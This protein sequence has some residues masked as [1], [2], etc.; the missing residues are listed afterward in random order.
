MV[1]AVRLVIDALEALSKRRQDKVR[2]TFFYI[3]ETLRPSRCRAHRGRQDVTP[4]SERVWDSFQRDLAALKEL[5]ALWG[6]L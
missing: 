5:G 1:T 6:S 2:F 3:V 4:S